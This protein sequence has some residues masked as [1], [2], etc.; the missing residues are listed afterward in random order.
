MMASSEL[1][2]EEIELIKEHFDGVDPIQHTHTRLQL[3]TKAELVELA[4]V[5][6][7]RMGVLLNGDDYKTTS[8]AVVSFASA[9]DIIFSM[10]DSA[11]M[12]TKATNPIND[13]M[14]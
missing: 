10:Y 8:E 7:N 13:N 3:M 12:N 4:L 2:K 11:K 5:S 9:A 1:Q 14:Q 6:F